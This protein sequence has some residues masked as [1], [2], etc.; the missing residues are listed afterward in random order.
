MLVLLNAI[1]INRISEHVAGAGG[2]YEYTKQ[3]FGVS[4]GSFVGWVYIIYQVFALAFIGLSNAIFVPALLS[5]VFNINVPGWLWIPLLVATEAF[6]F[7]ISYLGVKG[8]STV[9]E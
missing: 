5:S 4:M 2:Y 7:A 8:C 3:G 9:S 1:V 6:G